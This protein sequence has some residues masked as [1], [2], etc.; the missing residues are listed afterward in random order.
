MESVANFV[1]QPLYNDEGTPP[2][3][4]VGLGP[5]AALAGNWS[6]HGFNA[7]WRPHRGNSD[8]FLEL[9]V[10]NDQIDL[11]AINGEIPNRGLVQP[12]IFMRG[13]TYLQQI[14]DA[15]VTVNGVPAGLH[16]EP[17]VWINIP[18]LTDPQEPA[19]VTRMASIPHGTTILIQGTANTAAGGPSIPDVSLTP[20][21]IGHRDKPIHFIEQHLN[22]TT[23][24]RTSGVGLTGVTQAMLDNPNS[25]L[26]GNTANVTTTTRIH[27][28]T[29]P[30]DIVGGGASNMAFLVGANNSPNADVAHVDATFWLQTLA[31]EI[32]PTRLQYSQTV[33]LN[34]NGLSWPHIT[35][36]TLTKP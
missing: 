5:L 10:T 27:V 12:Q 32:K 24:F 34:F 15:N 13:L 11:E 26:T 19:A 2:P 21:N 1:F 25:V 35:V 20:F 6:G 28:S 30:G 33:L 16:I 7:I 23:P 8:H 4:T 14:S 22:K 29:T 9:N 17:G 31:G 36:A 18:A 3:A